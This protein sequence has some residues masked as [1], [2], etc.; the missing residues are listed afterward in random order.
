MK[1]KT[2]FEAWSLKEFGARLKV[3][4]IRCGLTQLALAE[5]I[6]VPQSKIAIY[7]S[8]MSKI[9][10]DTIAKIADKL[11]VDAKW[12]KYGDQNIYN[13]T[14]DEDGIQLTV[15]HVT[16]NDGTTGPVI[17]DI[18][19]T[20]EDL[21]N[22]HLRVAHAATEA[23]YYDQ[24]D[25][26]FRDFVEG[27]NEA[28]RK[29]VRIAKMERPKKSD[30]LSI[31]RTMAGIHESD[32]EIYEKIKNGK[33]TE[34]EKAEAAAMVYLKEFQ[35]ELYIEYTKDR[36]EE[37]LKRLLTEILDRLPKTEEKE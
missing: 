12:L 3:A 2:K 7:E 34:F 24:Y 18:I 21:D 37:N 11:N 15:S 23:L 20:L 29:A 19:G 17:S 36:S 14:H 25:E 33:A 32:P 1:E 8:G 28:N 4:R 31:A 9:R 26:R 30:E 10:D 13:V 5:L 6:D 16:K 35:P 27:R 22:D